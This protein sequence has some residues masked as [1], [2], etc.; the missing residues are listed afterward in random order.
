MYNGA[1]HVIYVRNGKRCVKVFNK[2]KGKYEY[3]A[4]N[5]RSTARQK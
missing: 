2:T 4:I 1:P 5:P 3:K